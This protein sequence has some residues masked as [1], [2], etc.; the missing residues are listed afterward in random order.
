VQFLALESDPCFITCRPKRGKQHA[1]IQASQCG[2]LWNLAEI[3]A[4]AT[5]GPCMRAKESVALFRSL[6]AGGSLAEVLITLGQILWAQE[7]PT[8][9]EEAIT[10]ALHL[11]LAVGPRLMV[12]AALEGLGSVVVA[13]GRAELAA[14]LLAGAAALR[15]EMGTPVRPVDQAVVEQMLATA[16]ST[17]G[18]DVFAAV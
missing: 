14:H 13:Q 8:A 12:A 9:A 5:L 2:I 4:F 17:L 1:C 6:Q 10:E 3:S 15:A 7:K 11:A 16:R 18:D